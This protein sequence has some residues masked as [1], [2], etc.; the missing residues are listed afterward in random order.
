MKL[1]IATERGE[2]FGF[3]LYRDGSATVTV[4][5]AGD[6]RTAFLSR[7][8]V[9]KLRTFLGSE[10]ECAPFV[11]EPQVFVPD[12]HVMSWETAPM[13]PTVHADRG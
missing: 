12:T 10:P 3:K 4:H 5:Q 2:Q 9:D 1:A 8:D 6:W 11:A 13:V 7:E